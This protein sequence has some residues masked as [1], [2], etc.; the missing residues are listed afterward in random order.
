MTPRTA[1]AFAA[2]A[3]VL[4]GCGLKGA[5]YLPEK[6]TGDV[7]IRPAPTAPSDPSTT[8]TPTETP[9]ETPAESS[10]PPPGDTEPQETSPPDTETI[11][12]TGV[13]SG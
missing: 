9:G 8:G 2:L 11:P 13:H 12:P 6:P 5:L 1:T 10:K 3:L 4:A 7:V